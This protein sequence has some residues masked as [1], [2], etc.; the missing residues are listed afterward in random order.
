MGWNGIKRTG[1]IGL[2]LFLLSSLGTST[3]FALFPSDSPQNPPPAAQAAPAPPAAQRA[4]KNYLSWNPLDVV[5]SGRLT[6]GYERMFRIGSRY[7]GLY[8]QYTSPMNY[9][10]KGMVTSKDTA[11]SL[12]DEIQ[13]PETVDFF[14]NYYGPGRSR[15]IRY[16]PRIGLSLVK[17]PEQTE[18][19]LYLAIGPSGRAIFGKHIHFVW[20]LTTLKFKLSGNKYYSWMQFPVFDLMVGIDF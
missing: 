1:K 2:A 4:N 11:V 13:F 18:R 20:A 6:L 5:F 9:I 7:F 10:F 14:I 15:G 12:S 8:F 16:F 3:A 19:A 17:N